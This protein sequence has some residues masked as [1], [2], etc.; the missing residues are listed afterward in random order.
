MFCSN[1]GKQLIPD[2]KFCANCGA[3]LPAAA[4]VQQNTPVQQAP[5]QQIAPAPVQQP[6]VQQT[7]PAPVQQPPVQQ[8]A[9]APVQQAPVQQ[10]APMYAYQQPVQPQYYQAPVK[11]KNTGLIIAIIAGGV[12]LLGVIIAILLI[13]FGGSSET[14][15]TN[16]GSTNGTGTYTDA[17][18]ITSGNSGYFPQENN[19]SEEFIG[20]YSFDG[21]DY[22]GVFYG[23]RCVMISATDF[24]TYYYSVAEASSD[25]MYCE[26]TLDG[27]TTEIY[28]NG[29]T[30]IFGDSVAKKLSD[31]DDMN[32]NFFIGVWRCEEIDETIVVVDHGNLYVEDMQV[33]YDIDSSKLYLEDTPYNYE[34]S[35]QTEILSIEFEGGVCD[36]QRIM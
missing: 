13:I 18:D 8:T 11:K 2:A 10:T 28:K 24:E 30:Y 35:V 5:V 15:S 32:D 9:P 29:S 36:Y 34:Y 20:V 12:V 26:I 4:P 23:E 25:D 14:G 17:P 6:P 31:R 1:C 21:G 33:S 19:L 3:S 27:Q 7:A 16:T 22:Y